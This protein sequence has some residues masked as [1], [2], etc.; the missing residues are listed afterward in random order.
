MAGFQGNI[1]PGITHISAHSAMGSLGREPYKGVALC[2]YQ[3]QF[4][5]VGSA[6]MS[7]RIWFESAF[8]HGRD[9]CL[10]TT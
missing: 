8:E 9:Y 6:E 7:D 10:D 2:L 1:A 3:R 4:I 5:S